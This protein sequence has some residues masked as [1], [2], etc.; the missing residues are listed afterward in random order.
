[1]KEDFELVEFKLPPEIWEKIDRV[2]KKDSPTNTLLNIYRRS[3]FFKNTKYRLSIIDI[4]YQDDP[5]DMDQGFEIAISDPDQDNDLIDIFDWGD[6]I[7][8]GITDN[9]VVDYI[10]KMSEL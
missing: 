3:I 7:L 6:C 5:Y 8:R 2:V 9:E 10:I 1:M 4:Q